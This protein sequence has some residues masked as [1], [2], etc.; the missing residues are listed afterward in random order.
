MPNQ[1]TKEGIVTKSY[2]EILDELK[3]GFYDIYGDN[4]TFEQD[5]PDGQMLNIF[6]LAIKDLLEYSVSIF[7]SFDPDIAIGTTLDERCA[8]NGVVRK[9]GTYTIIPIDITIRP[10]SSVTLTGLNDVAIETPELA[11]T[12][13]DNSGNNFYLLSGAT[14]NSSDSEYTQTLTFRC[15]KLGQV[16]VALNTVTNI[17]TPVVGVMTVTN[18]ENEILIGVDEELDKDLRVRREKAVGFSI[19]GSVEVMQ[20]R[21]RDLEDVKDVVIYENT[22]DITDSDGIPSHSIWAIVEG[23]EDKKIASTM[24]LSLNCGCGVRGSEVVNVETIYGNFQPIKFDRPINE[25]LYI[26]FRTTKEYPSYVYDS[27]EL[28]TYL[29]EN[30][31]LGI[32]DNSTVTDVDAMLKE[33]DANLVYTDIQLSLDGS[34]WEDVLITPSTKQKKF[35]LSINNVCIVESLYV[36][37]SY[38]GSGN[39]NNVVTQ[40]KAQYYPDKGADAKISDITTLLQTIGSTF[41]FSNVQISLD[42]VSWSSAN[43]SPLSEQ[44]RFLVVGVKAEA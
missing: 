20:A 14:I 5:S 24:Y 41:T 7:N 30:Y 33:A 12:V 6:T 2:N 26:R 3:Q 21:I 4:V 11:F 27:T 15:A 10:N 28:I 8:Y 25:D 22:G 19:A 16:D 37:F 43:I 31:K 18:S 32:Y 40:F 29:V 34:T 9:G 38:S 35:T 13:S 23:G 39:I 1:I 42:N 36:K 17:V 44:H